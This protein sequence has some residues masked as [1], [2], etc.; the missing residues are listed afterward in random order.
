MLTHTHKM[1]DKESMKSLTR[2]QSV[3][4]EIVL[5][6]AAENLRN[7]LHEC[8]VQNPKFVADHAKSKLQEFTFVVCGAPRTGKSTLINAII[9][10]D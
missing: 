7:S 9:N 2:A 4:S 3:S 5:E 6:V 8:E 1:T 10:Q